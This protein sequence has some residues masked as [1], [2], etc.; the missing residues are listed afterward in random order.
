M[1]KRVRLTRRRKA[2][3]DNTPYPGTVNQ[4]DRT[5]KKRDQYDNWDE[6]VNH[7]LP[8]M[9]HE[10][11]DNPRDDI[12]FGIP[13]ESTLSVA[14]IRVAA[15]KAVRLAVLLLGEKV[16]DEA[17]E[18]QARDFMGMT[19]ESLDRSLARF[20]DTQTLYEAEDKGKEEEEKAAE[21]IQEKKEEEAKKSSE[22]EPEV[23]KAQDEDEEEEKDEESKEA[24]EEKA[25]EKEASTD[26]PKKAQDDDDDDDDDDDKDE[27]SK[28]A[29]EESK[30]VKAEEEDKKEEDKKEE[31]KKEEDKKEAS[32]DESKTEAKEETASEEAKGP[33]ELD[34]ELNASTGDLEPDTEADARLAQLFDDP[35]AVKA[36]QETQETEGSKKAGIT[37][38]G[39]QPKVASEGESADI[40]SI[41]GTAPDVSDIFA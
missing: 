1:A 35:M 31:D 24:S 34:I 9:R 2:V 25:E 10:W 3:E 6:V 30:E 22:E 8:D 28:E 19:Q 16:G 32:D 29:S 41:W 38:L 15:N 13:K 40:S 7:P 4:P 5:F 27:E 37:K 36:E 12:G 26:E 33:N 11:Q 17:I 20:A 23:K 21:S 39:G 18:D 14:S